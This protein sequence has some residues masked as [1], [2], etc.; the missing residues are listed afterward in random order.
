MTD[1]D[2]ISQLALNLRWIVR[3]VERRP[4]LW[5]SRLSL[6]TRKTIGRSRALGL[7][8][9]AEAEADELGVFQDVTG[10]DLEELVSAPLYSRDLPL[11]ARNL[12]HLVE[13]IPY[14]QAKVAATR[15]GITDGQLSR[16]KKWGDQKKPHSINLRKLLKFHGMDPDL[17]LEEVPI[18]L[19]M[20]PLSGYAQKEWVSS[21]V[22]EMPASEVA[23]IYP[24]L[25]KLLRYD[26]ED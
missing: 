24:A 2:G 16:W 18:F 23:K 17:D 7:L 19:S 5:A 10:H 14:G 3:Q 12:R 20:E 26:E 15:I 13:A 21:R 4:E 8:L 9:G 1:L 6:M 22:Q 25:K 11:F